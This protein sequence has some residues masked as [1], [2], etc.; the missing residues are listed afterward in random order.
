MSLSHFDEKSGVILCHT[1]WGSWWQTVHDVHIEVLLQSNIKSKDIKVK[2]SPNFLECS[3]LNN[4][5][6]KGKPFSTIREDDS[7]W[8]IE[9]G[10]GGQR[11]LSVVLTKADYVGKEKIWEA[12]MADRSY[13][14]DPLTFHEMRKKIDLEKFQIENPGMDFSKAKLQKCYDTIPGYPPSES[15]ELQDK[16]EAEQQQS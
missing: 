14:P 10:E 13:Q 11:V 5:V 15:L 9:D 12:L 2:I 16:S 8:T 6:I 4:T 1:S 7:L 3:V